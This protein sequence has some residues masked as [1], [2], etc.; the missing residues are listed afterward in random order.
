MNHLWMQKKLTRQLLGDKE[1]VKW[2][3]KS[4]RSKGKNHHPQSVVQRKGSHG[5]HSNY[6]GAKPRHPRE[7][8]CAVLFKYVYR[9]C[10]K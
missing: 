4:S 2:A 9:N 5:S 3:D 7:K 10:G 6:R 8:C 1:L